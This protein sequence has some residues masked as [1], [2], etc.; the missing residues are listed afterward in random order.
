MML[1]FA[2]VGGLLAVIAGAAAAQA[3]PA[4]CSVAAAPKQA[5]QVS[6]GGAKFTPKVVK[7]RGEGLRKY[8]DDEFDSYRLALRSEDDISPPME[9]EVVV[10]VRKGQGIDGR[11]FRRLPVKETRKQPAPVEGLPEVQGWSF[12]DRPGGGNFNHVEHVA[13]MRLAFGKRK[14]DTIEG[15]IYL[16]VPKGQTT[17]FNKTPTKEDSFAI[18]AFQARIEK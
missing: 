17:M 8:G 15:S 12:K 4:D 18:G 11:T 1:R 6:V 2:G 10:I 13:S 5:L 9:S 7:L 3:L 14:G 16:C